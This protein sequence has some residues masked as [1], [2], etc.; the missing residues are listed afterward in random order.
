MPLHAPACLHARRSPS[1]FR[2]ARPTVI[3]RVPLVRTLPVWRRFCSPTRALHLLTRRSIRPHLRSPPSPPDTTHS[4]QNIEHRAM[5]RA[6]E[7]PMPC[8]KNR[9]LKNSVH[10]RVEPATNSLAPQEANQSSYGNHPPRS[11]AQ[12]FGLFV[13]ENI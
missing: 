1:F 13:L 6:R 4:P 11:H 10:P 7:C 12:I 3:T 5:Q 8:K 2:A 9:K